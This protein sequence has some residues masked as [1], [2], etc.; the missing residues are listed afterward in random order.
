MQEK[1]N[2]CNVYIKHCAIRA[3][4]KWKHLT[5]SDEKQ[6]NR[7]KESDKRDREM[8]WDKIKEQ[9]TYHQTHTAVNVHI[10]FVDSSFDCKPRLWYN[11]ICTIHSIRLSVRSLYFHFHI[12]HTL[13][14]KK[15]I[16][17]FPVIF[18]LIWLSNL[19]V[20]IRREKQSLTIEGK[21]WNC[22]ILSNDL[23]LSTFGSLSCGLRVTY[24]VCVQADWLLLLLTRFFFIPFIHV[25]SQWMPI[26][27]A[28]LSRIQ[29]IKRDKF[30]KYT[31]NAVLFIPNTCV[32]Q[33]LKLFFFLA[34]LHIFHE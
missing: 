2:N 1:C 8:K 10:L 7:K 32:Q 21:K 34:E 28:Y 5:N 12:Y 13:I 25:V 14:E 29:A 19:E 22:S 4:L 23:I 15:R 33:N 6:R 30:M 17:G 31:H 27:C 16:D 3:H 11:W 18:Y 24:N 20:F 9:N 26:F